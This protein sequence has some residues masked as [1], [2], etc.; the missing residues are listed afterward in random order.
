M[1]HANTFLFVQ[2]E[3]LISTT[4]KFRFAQ[5]DVE[6]VGFKITKDAI[7]L[8][9]SMT[10]SIWNVPQPRNI[11]DARALDLSSKLALHFQNVM[12]LKLSGIV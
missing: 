7:I 12:I 9:D 6:F 2:E 8:A 5:N 4:T 11:S 1:Q 10:A 3:V